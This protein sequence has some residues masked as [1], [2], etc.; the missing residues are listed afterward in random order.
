MT[1]I[2]MLFGI[3]SFLSL[4]ISIWWMII[5]DDYSKKL[6]QKILNV[7]VCLLF[8]LEGLTSILLAILSE[9]F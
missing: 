5:Y 9:F 3:I 8:I 7:L 6:I 2:R 1:T 4:G